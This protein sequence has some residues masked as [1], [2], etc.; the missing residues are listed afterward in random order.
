MRDVL[1][2]ARRLGVAIAVLSFAGYLMLTA[3]P[4]QAAVICSYNS[5]NRQITVDSSNPGVT[6][7]VGGGGAITTSDT[8][9][10]GTSFT[11]CGTA[12]VNNTDGITVNASD[13]DDVVVDLSGGPFAPGETPEASGTSEI[14]FTIHFGGSGSLDDLDVIGSD[15]AD[16]LVVGDGNAGVP[17]SGAA[18]LNGDNDADITFDG[19]MDDLFFG[20]EDGNDSISYAGGSATGGD[21]DGD[22]VPNFVL[23]GGDGDDTLVGSDVEG[24]VAIDGQEGNDLL[25]GGGGFD[26]IFDTGSLDTDTDGDGNF[27]CADDDERDVLD[28]GEDGDTLDGAG[29]G[30]DILRGGNGDDSEFGNGCNDVLDEGNGPNGADTLDGDAGEPGGPFECG[31]TDDVVDYSQRNSDLD[32]SLGDGNDNDGEVGANEQD[33]VNSGIETVLGGSGDD[34]IEDFDG[35]DTFFAGG[36]GNDTLLGD[37]GDDCV[38]GGAGDDTLDGDNGLDMVDYI[39]APNGVTVDL[40]AGTAT[41]HGNDTLTLFEGINGSNFDD[42]LSGNDEENRIVGNDGN[43]TIDG[44]DDDDEAFG[45]DGNDTINDSGDSASEEEE[46]SGGNGT[47][48]MNGGIDDDFLVGDNDND[49]IEGGEGDDTL[50]GS[51]GNDTL[52][53]SGA[54]PLDNDDDLC[55]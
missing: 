10:P 39:D 24:E 3:L 17:G 30:R 11:Q 9:F 31:G 19:G 38:Q 34:T 41:G 51:D 29:T 44:R 45:G 55:G 43:D 25:Q 35:D 8:V 7:Q 42:T 14:E 15:G 16:N 1:S 26:N 49:T 20:G 21:A 18:N 28:G 54:D 12:T 40:L 50:D 33:D 4:A 6:L 48:N 36:S 5:V 23:N 22:F 52:T 46:I 47:D 2:G 37:N 32:V 13:N 53:D 27:T